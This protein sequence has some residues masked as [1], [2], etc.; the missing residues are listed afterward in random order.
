[1]EADTELGVGSDPS[2]SDMETEKKEIH[3]QQSSSMHMPYNF[4]VI[5]L[6]T[7]LDPE[8]DAGVVGSGTEVATAPFFIPEQSILGLL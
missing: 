6:H 1:M 5:V 2:W 7:I 3:I 8:K 4:P